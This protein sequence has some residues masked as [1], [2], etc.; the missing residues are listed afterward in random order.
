[1]RTLVIATEHGKAG[2]LRAVHTDALGESLE[3]AVSIAVKARHGLT[4]TVHS[5]FV[6]DPDQSG[7][8]YRTI[9]DFGGER[10]IA[11]RPSPIYTV[12][13]VETGTLRRAMVMIH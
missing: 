13:R 9:E 12:T 3:E 1:M 10:C 6:T 2:Q 4:V 7:L 8:N 11:Y 5:E